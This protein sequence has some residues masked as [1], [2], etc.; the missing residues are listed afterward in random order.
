MIG[1]HLLVG[2]YTAT[3]LEAAVIALPGSLLGMV[4]GTSRDRAPGANHD[5]ALDRVVV[6]DVRAVL[7]LL[8]RLYGA[9]EVALELGL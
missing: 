1:G 6:L 5:R 8:V 4:A 9:V 3:V 7:D 2:N